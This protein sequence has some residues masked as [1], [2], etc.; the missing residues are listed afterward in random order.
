[1]TQDQAKRIRRHVT[2]AQKQLG[3]MRDYRHL[4]YNHGVHADNL[5]S[6]LS[7]IL[8][9]L[10]AHRRKIYETKPVDNCCRPVRRRVC[11]S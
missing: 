4:E 3:W 2:S 8:T 11:R 10:N 7:A 6:H 1:M 5:G 9:V